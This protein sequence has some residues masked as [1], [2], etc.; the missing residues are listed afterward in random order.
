MEGNNEIILVIVNLVQ[1]VETSYFIF[2]N[3][4]R[5]SNILFIYYKGEIILNSL[6]TL[7]F[8]S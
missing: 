1:L 3:R 6:K 7:G 5:T 2:K 4:V 8:L